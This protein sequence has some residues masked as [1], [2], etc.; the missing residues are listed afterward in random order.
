MTR[1]EPDARG[2]LQQAALELFAERGFDQTTVEDIASRAGVTK[3][4]FFRYFSDKRE[5]LFP[6]GDEFT[7]P[8]VAGL[9][10][11]APTAAPLEAAA[12]SLEA[13]GAGFPAPREYARQRRL[14][15]SAN[16]QLQE[17]EL[18]K[19]ASVATALA[20]ALRDRGVEEPTA[21]LTAETTIAV[22][23]TAFDRW[24]LADDDRELSDHIH[25]S[26][27]ALRTL[28]RSP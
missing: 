1:W 16:A 2:R 15:I 27:D 20:A 14:V 19:L 5:V 28:T 4:T 3:R 6:A 18:V 7:A 26:L 10:S 13:I 8:F 24:L 23:R 25:E 9:A 11:A 17:R 22:F 12:A 21:S